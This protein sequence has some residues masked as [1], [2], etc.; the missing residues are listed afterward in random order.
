MHTA[1]LP[2]AADRLHSYLIFNSQSAAKVK[3]GKYTT[4]QIHKQKSYSWFLTSPLYVEKGLEEMKLNEPEGINQK[5]SRMSV[6]RQSA[7]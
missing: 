5:K 1:G 3:S 4:R 2:N 7:Q 6:R